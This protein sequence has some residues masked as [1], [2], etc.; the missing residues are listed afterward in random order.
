MT[1]PGGSLL[2]S[3]LI[4]IVEVVV[5]VDKLVGDGKISESWVLGEYPNS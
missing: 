1:S 5:G 3:L 2:A 4:N